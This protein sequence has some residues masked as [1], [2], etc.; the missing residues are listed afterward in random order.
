MRKKNAMYDKEFTSK[1][2]LV[3]LHYIAIAIHVFNGVCG[4]IISANERQVL[5]PLIAPFF[6]YVENVPGELLIPQP[7]KVFSVNILWPNIAV[8]FITAAF[9]ILYVAQLESKSFATWIR[10]YVTDTSSINSL[11]WFEYAVTATMM[12]SF[13]SVAL[14]ANDFYFFLRSVSA[15]IALQCCGW[16][17]E[18]LDCDNYRDM[19][20][21]KVLWFA[22]GFNLNFVG[23]IVLMAQTFGSSLGKTIWYFVENTVPFAL[24]FQTFGAVAEYTFRRRWQFRDSYFSEKYYILLSL[25]TKVAV[26]WLSYGT[27]RQILEGN[28]VLEATPGINWLAV[29]IVAIILPAV[30]LIAYIGI[31]I[32][33]WRLLTTKSVK[34]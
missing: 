3:V 18:V 19:R 9:H 23:V 25:S 20:L 11:R 26:F 5:V 14:N 33:N 34:N 13:G 15:G 29:R 21:Y 27:Y 10:R 6:K 22:I 4:C 7:A 28:G 30:A 2:H 16:C 24:W 17:I 31:D 32:R 8:E 1:K 12:M